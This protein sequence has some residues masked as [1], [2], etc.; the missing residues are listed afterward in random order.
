MKVSG[1]SKHGSLI[2]YCN[3]LLANKGLS[4]KSYS[5]STNYLLQLP[6]APGESGAPSGSASWGRWGVGRLPRPRGGK[7]KKSVRMNFPVIRMIN[8]CV[9]I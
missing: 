6:R 9:R 4:K 7:K 2:K 8:E 5:V 3:Q 1:I